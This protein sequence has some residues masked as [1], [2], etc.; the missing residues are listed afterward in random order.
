[1]SVSINIEDVFEVAVRIERNSVRFYTELAEKSSGNTARDAFSVLAAEEEKHLGVF[2]AMLEKAV[3]YVPRF[4]Y[5]GRYE[6]YLRDEAFIA[7]PSIKAAE[8]ALSAKDLAGVLGVAVKLETET[9]RFYT[10][11]LAEFADTQKQAIESIIN[12]EK[13]HLKRLD[14]FKSGLKL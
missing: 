8:G 10:D 3:D 11:L 6:A 13:S 2:R 7:V 12:E 1:M 9:I 14:E 5:P 4:K